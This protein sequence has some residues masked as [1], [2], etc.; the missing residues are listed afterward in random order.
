MTADLIR[1]DMH[2]HTYRSFDCL[3]R[4]QAI[5]AAAA[6]RGIDRLIIT[7]HN[8]I[9]GA[10][11]ARELAPDRVIVGEEVKTREGFDIIGI[12]IEEVIPRGT[13]A[14]ETCIRIRDQGGVVYFPHPFDGSRAGGAR[15][16]QELDELVDVIEVHNARCFPRSLNRRAWKWARERG[17]LMGGGSDAHTVREVGRGFVQMPA[18][19][20]DRESLLR[21]LAIGQVLGQVSTSPLYRIASNYAKVRKFFDDR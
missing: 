17:K 1:V 6:E 15:F 10:V 14:R 13:P 7:D 8:E 3:S 20:H 12:F 4:P 2:L 11:E 9:S 18:F 21:A 5:L 16:L 19:S